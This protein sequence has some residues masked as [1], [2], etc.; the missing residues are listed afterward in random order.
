MLAVGNAFMI[1][2]AVV[3]LGQVP[4]VNEYV[5]VYVPGVDADKLMAPELLLMDNPEVELYVPPV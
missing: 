1:T 2:L 5:T 3:V 4:F